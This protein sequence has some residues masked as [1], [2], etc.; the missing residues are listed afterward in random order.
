MAQLFSNFEINRT[1][2]WPMLARI[3]V[4]SIAL[5]AIVV[6]ASFYVPAVRDT[7]NLARI[8]SEARYV[9]A[10]YQK[11]MIGERAEIIEFPHDRFQYP[12]GYFQMN[13]NAAAT[14]TPEQQALASQTFIVSAYVPP[15]P[16]P[17]PKPVIPRQPRMPRVRPAVVPK[18]T[19]PQPAVSPTP[20]VTSS[21]LVAKNEGADKPKTKE[22]AEKE[23]NKI[24]AS[25]NVERPNE[26]Q[27]N[28]RPLNDWLAHA[29][30]LKDKGEIKLDGDIEITIT[31]DRQPD[32]KLANAQIE[33][34]SGDESLVQTASAENA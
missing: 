8:F 18:A 9:D 4:G 16:P 10:D 21:P 23:L 28:K 13:T 14:L 26:D 11:T 3:L 5:H 31:A 27:I 33:S 29:K 6:A 32:G 2:R 1:P 34:K 15:P 24:A 25:N 30:Q 20:Q 7:L 19:T 17:T 12:E 22:D